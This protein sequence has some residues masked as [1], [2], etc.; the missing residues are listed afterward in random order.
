M[1]RTSRRLG[2]ALSLLVHL[3]LLAG[4]WL[5]QQQP[6]R[7]VAVAGEVVPVQLTMFAEAPPA[8]A[9]TA[10]PVAPPAPAEAPVDEPVERPVDEFVA[11]APPPPP[12]APAPTPRPRPVERPRQVSKPRPAPQTVVEPSVAEPAAPVS[13][14]A[15]VAAQPAA[16]PRS[17][18]RVAVREAYKAALLAAIERHKFYPSRA[19]RRGIEG[20]ARVGFRIV[21]DGRIEGIE[22]VAGSGVALLDQAAVQTM[23]RL[24]RVAPLPPELGMGHWDLVVPIDFRL[25]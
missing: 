7:E 24:G 22:L 8:P 14:S 10:A 17:A 3:G 15:P 19:R 11:A 25:L 12:V 20:Q 16:A 21:A 4:L 18:Q 1:I 5:W 23:Q 2:F 9:P 6:V 13:V